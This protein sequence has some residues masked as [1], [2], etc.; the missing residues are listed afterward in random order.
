[1]EELK[2]AIEIALIKRYGEINDLG[3]YKNGAWISTE[4]I[5]NLICEII[6]ENENLFIEE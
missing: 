5:L 4:T 2:N 3:C 6:N 1:M